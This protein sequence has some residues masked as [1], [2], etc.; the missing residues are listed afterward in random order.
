MGVANAREDGSSAEPGA[1]SAALPRSS[2]AASSF[3]TPT[4]REASSEADFQNLSYNTY[5]KGD[6]GFYLGQ[7]KRVQRLAVKEIVGKYL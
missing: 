4:G 1:E 6:F 2:D 7:G 5:F 3:G